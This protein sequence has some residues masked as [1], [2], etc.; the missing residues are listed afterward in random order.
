MYSAIYLPRL[1]PQ[2][3]NPSC[4]GFPDPE[5][6]QNW[7]YEHQLCDRCRAERA[8]AL[9]QGE[10]DS[11]SLTPPCVFEWLIL[12]T[13]AAQAATSWDDLLTA[14]GFEKIYEKGNST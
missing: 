7:V 14:G 12:P 6:A 10:T 4:D 5:S 1:Q 2:D 9:T 13:T 8:Q 11:H 3:E